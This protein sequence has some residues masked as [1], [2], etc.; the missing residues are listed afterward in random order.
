M[1][2]LRVCPTCMRRASNFGLAAMRVSRRMLYFL[3]IAEGVS[4]LFTVWILTPVACKEEF[5]LGAVASPSAGASAAEFVTR[6][7]LASLFLPAAARGIEA[8]RGATLAFSALL[9]PGNRTK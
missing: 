6:L 4:P 3:A 9:W 8:G 1:G 7:E 5:A 2:M